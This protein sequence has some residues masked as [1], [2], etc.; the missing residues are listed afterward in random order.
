DAV[1]SDRFNADTHTADAVAYPLE[2]RISFTTGLFAWPPLADTI[3]DTHLVVRDRLGR[4]VVFLARI[5]QAGLLP[6]AR[7]VYGLGVDQA[8]AVVVDPDGTATV[9]NAAGGGGGYLVRAS[10][11]PRL[12]PGQPFRYTVA[13]SH[14]ARNGE[15]FDLLHKTTGEPWFLLTVDGSRTPP[16]SRDPYQR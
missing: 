5:L 9:L 1:A 3:T 12:E 4:L 10:A 6:G 13:V 14:V 7:T 2:E 8:S 15:H 16:Y 11:P